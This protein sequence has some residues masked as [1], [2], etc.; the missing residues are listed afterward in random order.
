MGMT[1]ASANALPEQL[2]DPFI[3]SFTTHAILYFIIA[4]AALLSGGIIAAFGGL[5]LIRRRPL[6]LRLLAEPLV[7]YERKFPRPEKGEGGV[8]V[9]GKSSGGGRTLIAAR[10][11]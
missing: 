3:E 9:G 4:T 8:I 7:P 2:G 1:I 11:A 6:T 5:G 10:A